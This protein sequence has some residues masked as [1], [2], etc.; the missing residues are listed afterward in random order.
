MDRLYWVDAQL[1]R[2]EHVSIDGLD[3]QAFS[4]IGQITHPFSLTVHTGWHFCIS[5]FFT[6]PL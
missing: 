5:S 3:R 1:D 2:I 4:S 6:W